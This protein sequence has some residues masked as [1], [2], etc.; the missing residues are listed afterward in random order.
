MKLRDVIT[1]VFLTLF[2]VSWLERLISFDSERRFPYF[3][4]LFREF[5]LI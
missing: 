2:I 4:L 1:T 5:C 3:F